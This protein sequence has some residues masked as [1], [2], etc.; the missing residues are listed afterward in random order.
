VNA[1]EKRGLSPVSQQP[2]RLLL[3]EDNAGDARLVQGAI[4]EHATG[5]F[6]VV[7]VERLSQALQRLDAERFDVVLCDLGLPDSTGLATAEA[8]AAHA[9]AMPL[10]LLTGS[11]DQDLGRDAIQRGAQDYLVKDEVRG[12]VIVRTLRYAMERKRLESGLRAANEA[13]ECRVAERTAELEQANRSLRASESRFRQLTEMSSDFYWE[14]DAGHRLTQRGSS[15]KES[16]IPEF[17]GQEQFGLQ[18]WEIPYLAPGEE[19]WRAHRETLA[20]H[21]PFRDFEVLRLGVDGTPR[22][23]LVSGDPVFD[24][25][26]VFTGYIGVGTDITERRNHQTELQ[27]LN[28]S[29]EQRVRDRTRALEVA[30]RELESFSYSVSHDLRAPLRA[31]NGFS[32]LLEQQCAPQPNDDCRNFVKRIRAGS[33]KMGHLIEDLLSLSRLSRQPMHTSAVDLSALVC[34]LAEELTAADASRR[35]EWVIA[36]DVRADGDAGLLRVALQNLVGNAWKYSSRRDAARI[37]FGVTTQHGRPVY[38]VRDNGAGFDM[39]YADKLFTAFQRLHSSL[40]FPGT[41]IGLA[42]VARIVH[43][44]GGEVWADG[45]MDAGATFYFTLGTHNEGDA[46]ATAPGDSPQPG[47]GGV[48]A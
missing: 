38:F 17:Q 9:P 6:S 1:N 31:I 47:S 13:L 43:R 40:E 37:E 27:R 35:I 19:V 8:I 42:T 16:T 44:H 3:L 29:L 22:H 39:A 20:A 28:E 5:E 4:D 36:P 48:S 12:P 33:E 14:S 21:L 23:I 41:G 45:Q 2:L 18:R 26:G 11:H 30:N 25:S 32:Q 7:W 24:A 46:A 34:E 15:G 10:V